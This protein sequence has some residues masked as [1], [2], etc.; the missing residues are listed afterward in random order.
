MSPIRIDRY[1]TRDALFDEAERLMVASLAEAL[2]TQPRATIALSGGSTPEPL[3]RRVAGQ[4]VPWSRVA[5][6]L[7]DERW[8]P[9]NDADSNEAMIRRATES[10]E[11]LVVTGLYTG[12]ETP[13]QGLAEVVRRVD[14][15]P[16]PFAVTVLGMGDDGH[17]ASFFPG[18]DGLE[19]ALADSGAGLAVPIRAAGLRS[20]RITLTLPSVLSSR[21]IIVLLTGSRK[22]DVLERALQPGPVV[23]LPIRAVLR[24]T[25]TPVRVLWAG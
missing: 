20:P 22:L 15:L 19:S 17:T 10:A 4:S 5:A 12:H 7:V 2:E 6:T 11:G 16:R 23:E 25:R 18:S 13:E 3:Y 8:V 21:L 14:A 9:L 24:Q 1:P